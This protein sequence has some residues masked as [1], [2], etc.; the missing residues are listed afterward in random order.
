MEDFIYV[1]TGYKRVIQKDGVKTTICENRFEVV[2]SPGSDITEQNV[3]AL[4]REWIRWRKEQ[5]RVSGGLP[6]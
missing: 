1:E 4:M 6:E 3:V 2:S 5:M